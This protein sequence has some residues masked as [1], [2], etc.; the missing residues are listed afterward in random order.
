MTRGSFQRGERALSAAAP[1]VL[2]LLLVS[3]CGADDAVPSTSTTPISSAGKGGAGAR[4]ETPSAGTGSAKPGAG[5]GGRAGEPAQAGRAG[6]AATPA[7]SAGASGGRAGK[8]ESGGA[9]AAGGGG[10]GDGGD[11]G[12]GAGAGQTGQSGKGG[13]TGGGGKSPAAPTCKKAGGDRCGQTKAACAGLDP[14]ASSDCVSCCRVP[15]NPV[16]D[17]GF[18]DPFIARDGGTYY[19][20]ATGS[21]VRRRSSKDLV[22]WAPA[23]NAIE[24]SPWKSASAGFWAPT[25]YKA[26][27][28]KWVLYYAAETNAPNNS[29][30][31]IGK[32][33]AG[34]VDGDFADKLGKPFICEPSSW[35]IDPSVFQDQNGKDYLL[36][37]QDTAAMS[38]GNAWIQELDQNGDLVGQSHELISRASSEPSWELDA[39]GGVLEN[40]AMVRHGQVYHLFYSANRWETA[41][42]ANGHAVCDSPFGPCKKTSTTSPWQGSQGQMLGPGGADTVTAPDGTLFMYMHGWDAPKVGPGGERKL[43]LYRLDFEGSKPAIAPL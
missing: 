8:G 27:N 22:T 11:A 28:G 33:V 34:A 25:V 42:Y 18:A 19:A 13:Q 43:W 6:A 32:A 9:P 5:S 20:F 38:K 41:K 30:H 14:I 26:K 21:T 15:T 17:T 23:T 7:G 12:Q 36:W 40:P 31:C 10:S 29:Q 35:S 39:Q 2:A 24:K 3:A 4:G 1:R 16:I 37:R